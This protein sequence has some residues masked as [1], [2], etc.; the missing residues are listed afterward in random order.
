M[1]HP[2]SIALGQIAAE[3]TKK[4]TINK[5][6]EFVSRAADQGADLIVFPEIGMTQFFPQFQADS[7]WFEEAEPIPGGTTCDAMQEV[8]SKH[9]IAIVVS[10]YEVAIA[11]VSYNSA[12]V[13]DSSGDLS[14][15][16]R[17]ISILA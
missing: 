11:G 13:I 12:A 8:A 17:L 5:A 14:G 15:F 3:Q 4:G 10:I 2:F 1:S 16:Q 9:K 7:K 6:V